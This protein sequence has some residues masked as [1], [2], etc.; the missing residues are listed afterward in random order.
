MSSQC[1]P[2]GGHYIAKPTQ[3]ETNQ[4]GRAVILGNILDFRS[5]IDGITI[6]YK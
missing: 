2:P 4:R 6:N 1:I 5:A 3:S